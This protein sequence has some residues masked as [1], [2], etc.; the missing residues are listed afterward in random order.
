MAQ[1]GFLSAY[2]LQC[3]IY[4]CISKERCKRTGHHKVESVATIIIVFEL[5]LNYYLFLS[6]L[7]PEFGQ[8]SSIYHCPMILSLLFLGSHTLCLSYYTELVS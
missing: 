2:D 8:N 4:T 5:S 1:F 3:W 6:Y 7:W